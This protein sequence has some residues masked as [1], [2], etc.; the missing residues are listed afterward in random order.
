MF[1]NIDA[2]TLIVLIVSILISLS[3]HEFMHALVGYKLGDTTAEQDGRLSL[4][5]LRHI[6]PFMTVI[7]PIITL[8]FIGAPVLAAKPVPFNPNFVKFEE[9]GGA[10]IAIAGPLSNLA[11]AVISAL[12]ASLLMDGSL[13]EQILNIFTGLNVAIFVFNLI[14]IPPL[15]G[16]RVLYAFAPGP[17]QQFMEQI[18][19]YGFFII[20]FLVFIG[21]F[22]GVITHLN[23]AI[24]NFLP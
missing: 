19:P 13:P 21:G 5:P 14:P 24:L 20:I 4:N 15:D 12:V 8:V 17:V 11:M 2:L 10:L 7:L 23:D 16:S 3:V 22:G 1:G 6:D 18:E 9:Y